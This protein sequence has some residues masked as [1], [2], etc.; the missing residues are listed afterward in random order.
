[1]RRGDGERSGVL[2]LEFGADVAQVID[3]LQR[4]PRGCDDDLAAGGQGRKALALTNENRHAELLLELTYL[5]AYSGL[6]SEQRLRCSG[7]V[8]P[9]V[10]DRAKVTQLLQVQ[11]S[12]GIDWTPAEGQII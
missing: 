6:R 2:A 11:G 1:M 3:L 4:T 8:E 7:D 5:L 10:D 12:L 9:M